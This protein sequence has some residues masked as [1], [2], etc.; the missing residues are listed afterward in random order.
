[1]WPPTVIV[2]NIYKSKND[3]QKDGMSNSEMESKLRGT[4]S[5]LALPV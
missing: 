3:G 5:V 2:E 1:L 4:S